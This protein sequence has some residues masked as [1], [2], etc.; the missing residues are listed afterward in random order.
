M[1][2]FIGKYMLM[3]AMR[4]LIRPFALAGI[5]LTK[6]KNNSDRVLS[7]QEASGETGTLLRTPVLQ[8][9]MSFFE[10]SYLT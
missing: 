6:G 7:V 4:S 2:L 3:T 5:S 1:K 9:I 10:L 8:F